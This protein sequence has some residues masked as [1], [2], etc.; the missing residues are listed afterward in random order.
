MLMDYAPAEFVEWIEDP[1]DPDLSDYTKGLTFEYYVE[2]ALFE[3]E[4]GRFALFRGG[5]FGIVLQVTESDEV[6][7]EI[8]GKQL[9][10]R[11]M[12]WHTHPIPTGPSDHDREVLKRLGQDRSIVYE[13]NGE[14]GGTA[15][16]KD[17]PKSPPMGADVT[18]DE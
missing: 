14:P 8:A 2:H 15:F 4:N 5:H 16:G 9:R 3:L 10:V 12:L 18:D 1:A 7:V 17:K 11:R 6:R 13:I